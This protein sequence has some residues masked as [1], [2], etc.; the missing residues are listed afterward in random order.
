MF[1]KV[2]RFDAGIGWCEQEEQGEDEEWKTEAEY[3]L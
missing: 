1:G 3:R 2:A